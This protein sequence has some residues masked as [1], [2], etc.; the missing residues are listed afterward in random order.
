[1]AEKDVPHNR[2]ISNTYTHSHQIELKPVSYFDLGASFQIASICFL[3]S[4]GCD[5]GMGFVKGEGFEVDMVNRCK[6]EGYAKTSCSLPYYL[7][8][9]CPYNDN[10][11]IKC[12][13]DNVRACKDIGYE[14]TNCNSGYVDESSCPYD[15]SYKKCKCDPCE[16]YDYTYSQAV[17]S[18][19]VQDGT[20]MSCRT[21][22]YKRKE[23]PC[24]GYTTCEC[25][26]EVGTTICYSG[27]VKKFS[28][29]KTCCANECTLASC[30]TGNTCRYEACS[31][32][33]CVTGCAV[34]YTEWCTQLTT[35]NCNDMGYK[36]TT[37]CSSGSGVKCPYGNYWYCY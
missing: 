7:T 8:G 31:N 33:Y 23:N 20:C 18:G 10:Y 36:G 28:R 12:E 29:C 30:P 6:Q 11:Y 22:K 13:T 5:M 4:A 16:G 1:M 37:A 19:Y 14:E 21:T 2:F 27:S 3:G 32:K 9:Q 24:D 34:N 25:G 17:T 26:G 35:T 15:N